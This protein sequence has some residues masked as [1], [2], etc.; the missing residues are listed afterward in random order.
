MAVRANLF[1][2]DGAVTVP[3]PVSAVNRLF[4]APVARWSLVS[5][6]VTPKVVVIGS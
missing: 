2:L 4:S 3:L 5:V 6:R 1:P